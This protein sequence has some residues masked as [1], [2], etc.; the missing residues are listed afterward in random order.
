MD[1]PERKFFAPPVMHRIRGLECEVRAGAPPQFPA[2]VAGG[3]Y[4][5]V[6]LRGQAVVRHG[7]QALAVSRHDTLTIA[8]AG[9]PPAVQATV[10]SQHVGVWLDSRRLR[11]LAGEE[12]EAIERSLGHQVAPSVAP[13]TS[14]T[15][16]AAN[17][18]VVV[19]SSAGSGRLLRDAKCLEL[20]AR[21]LRAPAGNPALQLTPAQRA[22]VRK[23]HDLLL[24]DLAHPPGVKALARACGLNTFRLKQGFRE[25]YG[26]SIRATYHAERM[27]EAWRLIAEERL[28]V[29]EAGHRVG[30]VNLSH[31]CD[32]FRRQFGLRPGELKRCAEGG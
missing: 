30:Y 28:S 8:L 2:G 21:L 26:Q 31:F 19:L 13:A 3:V 17:E 22:C 12:G 24:A 10:C 4:W 23:A 27:R 7:G 16:R 18:L 25:I 1:H 11:D 5:A 6:W 20:L 15:L 32:A 14:D 9:A 29:G